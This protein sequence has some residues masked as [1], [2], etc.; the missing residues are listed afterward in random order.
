MSSVTSRVRLKCTTL[1]TDGSTPAGGT[2]AAPY[3][4]MTASP[5]FSNQARPSVETTCSES[6]RDAWGNII[7]QFESSGIRDPGTMQVSIDWD[8][9]DSAAYAF[10]EA[11]CRDPENRPYVFEWPES[12]DWSTGPKL[13]FSGHVTADTPAMPILVGGEARLTKNL[14]WQLNGDYTRTAPVART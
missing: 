12:K 9:H 8:V 4:C 14:T 2:P 13:N 11:L 10:V 6:P 7:K 3:I 5:T 1:D